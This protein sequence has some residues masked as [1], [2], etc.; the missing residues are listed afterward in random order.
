[1]FFGDFKI[2]DSELNKWSI[3]FSHNRNVF[4]KWT[5]L[6]INFLIVNLCP[7]KFYLYLVQVG[8]VIN[9]KVK[10]DICHCLMSLATNSDKPEKRHFVCKNKILDKETGKL[11][12]CGKR[13]SV[14]SNTWFEKSKL[15]F[16]V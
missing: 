5:L 16:G 11:R 9:T 15:N 6:F 2:Y 10:C 12:Q 14:R 13:K 8:F 3:S 7:E 1:M 4:K